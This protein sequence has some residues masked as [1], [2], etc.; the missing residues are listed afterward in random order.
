[1]VEH[2]ALD[3][4]GHD[5]QSATMAKVAPT[6]TEGAQHLALAEAFA[7]I[8]D[9]QVELFAIGPQFQIDHQVETPTIAVDHRIDHR[10]MERMGEHLGLGLTKPVPGTHTADNQ[11]HR[12]I[13]VDESRWE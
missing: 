13:A 3:A 8:G 12:V 11:R 6:T 2:Q 7:L 10:F 5:H 9:V 4:S 1:M